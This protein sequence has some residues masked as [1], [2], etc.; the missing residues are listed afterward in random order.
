MNMLEVIQLGLSP[1]IYSVG[2]S[3]TLEANTPFT[4]EAGGFSAGYVKLGTNFIKPRRSIESA[5]NLYPFAQAINYARE[6]IPYSPNRVD[7]KRYKN[8]TIFQKSAVRSIIELRTVYGPDADP[9]V[10]QGVDPQAEIPTTHL[11]AYIHSN[12]GA[13]IGLC[14]EHSILVSQFILHQIKEYEPLS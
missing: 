11:F 9:S 12:G 3:S 1:V 6:V 7:D 2:L 5:K 13:F 4:C 8:D 14:Q 10:T